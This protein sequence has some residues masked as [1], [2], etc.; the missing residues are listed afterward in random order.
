MPRAIA[1]FFRPPSGTPTPDS[2]RYVFAALSGAALSFSYSGFY[3]SVYSYVCLGILLIVLFGARPKVAFLC[4]GLHMLLFVVTCVPWI[5]TVLAVHGGVPKI[6]GWGIVLLIGIFF[7]IMAGAFAWCVNRLAQRS[8]FLACVGA[9]FLWVSLEFLRAKF[10]EISFPWGLLGYPASANPALLQITTLTGIYG[11]SFFAAAVNSILAWCDAATDTSVRRRVTILVSTIVLLLAIHFI[12]PR[13]VPTPHAGHYARAV[14]LNFPEVPEFAATW[15][16][17]HAADLDEVEQLSLEPSPPRANGAAVKPDLLIW[18][19]APAPFS[20]QDASYLKRATG[21]AVKFGHPFLSGSV[22]WRPLANES[23]AIERHVLVPYNS[24]VMV[25][26]Q[27]RNVFTYDKI[28]LVPFGEYEPFPLIHRVVKSVSSEIGG[29]AKGSKYA[30]AHLSGRYTFSTFICYEAI[31]PGE[32]RHFAAN[33]ADTVREHFQRRMV[34]A[35]GGGRAAFADRAC[36]RRREPPMYA[37]RDQ[38]RHHRV[39]RSVRADFS[40]RCRRMCARP[41]ICRTTFRTER[42]STRGL[43]IGSLG[44]AS[45]FPLFFGRNVPERDRGRGNC[46][47]R[48][49]EPTLD[50]PMQRREVVDVEAGPHRA[51]STMILEDL[52]YRYEGL[53]PRIALVRSFL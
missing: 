22:E 12:G 28:H 30:V 9:P 16:Q 1:S 13:F 3:L 10:P 44:C 50:A 51:N 33:G 6:A 19:E 34:R 31:Y 7:G 38:Q 35:L 4:G 45:S 47:S 23:G 21:L 20:F 40:A 49:I 8:I 2:F 41:S 5:A 29:F 15:F 43:G 11:L 53:K 42:R 14:Q 27:G 18:P 36:A 52:Q 37:T 25:D 39:G 46:D 26:P 48:G 17:N 24:A 32:I